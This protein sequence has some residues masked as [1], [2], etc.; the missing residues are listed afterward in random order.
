MV[1]ALLVI[2]VV[3]AI[4]PLALGASALAAG[5]TAAGTI[6]V[7]IAALLIAGSLGVRGVAKHRQ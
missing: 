1:N 4:M 5:N 2:T 7:A 3:A 6:P